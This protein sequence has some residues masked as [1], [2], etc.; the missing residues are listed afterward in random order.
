MRE[1]KSGSG[2]NLLDSTNV[3]YEAKNRGEAVESH[4]ARLTRWKYPLLPKSIT[5]KC[6]KSLKILLRC[7][8]IYIYLEILNFIYS[9]IESYVQTSIIIIRV[10]GVRSYPSP[11]IR[12]AMFSR[13]PRKRETESQRGKKHT[14]SSRH[15]RLVTTATR[16]NLASRPIKIPTTH[17][18]TH[19]RP[20][21]YTYTRRG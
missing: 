7:V 13:S 1:Q 12:T 16:P 18:H 21:T 8:Y 15:E 4:L 5:Y 17:T 19:T 9:S 20:T 11:L 2:I 10:L 14:R 3:F 6:T